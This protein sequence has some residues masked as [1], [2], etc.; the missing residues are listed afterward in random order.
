M[1]GDVVRQA[2]SRTSKLRELAA[3]GH[4]DAEIAEK[5]VVSSRT[6]LRWRQAARIPS[7]WQPAPVV[8]QHGTEYAYKHHKCRCDDCHRAVR[9]AQDARLAR[10]ARETGRH[11]TNHYERWTE[12]DD[13]VVRMHTPLEA[14]LAIGRT[15]NAVRERGRVLRAR[16]A[17]QRALAAASRQ[18][19]T[20]T[21]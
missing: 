10:Y 11:A 15:Y 18:E 4:S 6:V 14:A 9:V 20:T 13:A 2:R 5:L 8:I 1:T 21:A 19:A 17:L 12:H 3:A 16:D 7:C